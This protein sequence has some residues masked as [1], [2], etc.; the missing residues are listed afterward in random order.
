M[1]NKLILWGAVQE[2]CDAIDATKVTSLNTQI[3]KKHRQDVAVKGCG[4]FP[5]EET[6]P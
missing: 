1:I 4:Q 6:N 3:A 5:S 2:L